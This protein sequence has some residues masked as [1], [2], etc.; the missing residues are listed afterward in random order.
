MER[1][2][3]GEGDGERG[4]AKTEGMKRKEYSEE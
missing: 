3:D 4:K 2:G 1:D